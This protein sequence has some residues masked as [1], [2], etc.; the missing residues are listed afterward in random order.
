[1]SGKWVWAGLLVALCAASPSGCKKNEKPVTSG[2][3]DPTLV[4]SQQLVVAR[5]RHGRADN[6]PCIRRGMEDALTSA[7]LFATQQKPPSFAFVGK[8][9]P[10]T[11]ITLQD[12]RASGGV[13]VIT[14]G[15]EETMRGV[16]AQ[17]AKAL[18]AD[19][20]ASCG[21]VAILLPQ[22]AMQIR[23]VF[24]AGDKGE[25]LQPCTAIQGDYTKC[26]VGQAAWTSFQEDR[27]FVAT[28]KNWS[29]TVDRRAKIDLFP[30]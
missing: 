12:P 20:Y 4:T 26:E 11:P 13:S 2:S 18:A 21:T 1:M 7:K 6:P 10:V 30:R 22:D 28:F 19:S 8:D 14:Q 27:Y 23:V 15:V 9:I 3:G 16:G 29:D 17:A 25:N 5:G 24:S